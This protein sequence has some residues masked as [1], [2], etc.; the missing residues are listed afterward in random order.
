MGYKTVADRIDRLVS[1]GEGMKQLAATLVV[2]GALFVAAC[3]RGT[4]PTGV[5]DDRSLR[6]A[7]DTKCTA[8]NPPPPV[9]D[10]NVIV[11]RG[12]NCTLA[13]TTVRGNVIVKP[14]AK[15]VAR[16]GTTVYGNVQGDGARTIAVNDGSTVRGNVQLINGA[17]D[18]D[19]GG[20]TNSEVWGNALFENNPG[21]IVIVLSDIRGDIQLR[22]N[23]GVTDPPSVINLFDNDVGGNLQFSDNEKQGQIELNR[24]RGNL[25]CFGNNPPP[26]GAANTAQKKEGQCR[27]F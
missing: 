27:L 5:A 4:E 17:P 21:A 18:F 9:V 8:S 15:L 2:L 10:G 23:G 20:I 7:G 24:I 6:P 3:E 1:K 25:Q 26:I 19:S 14:L 12:E 22:K 11:P 13:G 16:T